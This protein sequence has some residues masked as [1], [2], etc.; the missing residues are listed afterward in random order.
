MKVL[1]LSIVEGKENPLFHQV[2]MEE[3]EDLT[4]TAGYDIVDKVIIPI[5]AIDPKT[6]LGRGKVEELVHF[7]DTSHLDA[8]IIQQEI[9]ASQVRA[10]EEQT[11]C[12]VITRTELILRIFALH[13]QT[14]IAKMQ[15]EL[16][17]LNYL[18]PRLVGKGKEMSRIRGGIGMRG[19]GEQ[20]LEMERRLVRRRIYQISQRLEALEKGMRE[21]R[22]R[23]RR[24]HHSVA[25]VGYTNAGK[26]SL[27]NA[28]THAQVCVEDKLFAT[29]DTTSRRLWLTGERGDIQVILTDTVGFIQDLPHTLVESFRSTLLETI[30]TDLII[31]VVNSVHPAYL[32]QIETVRQTLSEIQADT[33]PHIL[34]FNKIDLLETEQYLDLRR[35]FP[36]AYFLSA[37]TKENLSLLREAIY[38]FF[39]QKESS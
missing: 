7:Y 26:S 10:I 24:L 38:Q 36:S 19:P 22:K 6:Y 27:F 20:K 16:A 12:E 32:Q 23:R 17:Q 34:C 18:L 3:L 31:H 21:R 1:L 37:K 5:R 2:A 28:L 8:I 11:L 14:R 25:L 15:V 29:L 39:V 30:D 13:A 33:V 35:R 4:K 9:S